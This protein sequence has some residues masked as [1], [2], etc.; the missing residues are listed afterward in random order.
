MGKGEENEE[1]K[2][3]KVEGDCGKGKGVVQGKG[4]GKG[5]DFQSQ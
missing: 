4:K 5:R 2:G 3:G 1:D